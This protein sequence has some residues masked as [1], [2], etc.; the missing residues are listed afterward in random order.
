MI[1]YFSIDSCYFFL[2]IIHHKYFLLWRS[3]C[4]YCF[5]ILGK[6]WNANH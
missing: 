1:I 4:I 6:D 5:Y 3:I 2:Q